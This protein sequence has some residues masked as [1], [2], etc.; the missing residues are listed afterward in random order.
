MLRVAI[1]CARYNI[2]LANII[3]LFSYINFSIG[4]LYDRFVHSKSDNA[5]RYSGWQ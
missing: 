2:N 4:F 1:S 5:K 3:A